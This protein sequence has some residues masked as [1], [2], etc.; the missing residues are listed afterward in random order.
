MTLILCWG[1][2][3]S[4]NIS[5]FD[6]VEN[7]FNFW[8][9]L[10]PATAKDV[11]WTIGSGHSTDEFAFD[12]YLNPNG[13]IVSNMVAALNSYNYHPFQM[14]LYNGWNH[15]DLGFSS[16]VRVQNGATATKD[17]WNIPS[18]GQVVNGR[19][20]PVANGGVRGKGMWL[21][22]NHAFVSY[23]IGLQPENVN[24]SDWY[25]GIFVDPRFE[26][27]NTERA[28][29][30]FP[31]HTMI[32]MLGKRSIRYRHPSLGVVNEI[33]LPKPIAEKE[34]V[35]L[36]FQL[37]N[38]GKQVRFLLNGFPFQEWNSPNIP[39]M[40]SV[41]VT[42]MVPIKEM[43]AVMK[44]VAVT[45]SVAV[46]EKVAITETVPVYQQFFSL[47]SSWLG[48]TEYV[49][50]IVGYVEKV[51]GYNEEIVGYTEDVVG[52]AE[53]IAGYTQPTM[54][55]MNPGQLVV[56]DTL[57]NA[58]TH[59]LT[60]TLANL[61]N[62]NDPMPEWGVQPFRGWIDGF[63][64]LA[65]SPDIES[66]CNHAKGTLVGL[67]SDSELDLMNVANQ[68]SDKMHDVV[69]EQLRMRGQ[70]TYDSYACYHDYS[71]DFAA[72]TKNIPAGAASLRTAIQFPEGPIYHDAPRP[73][74]VYNE[75]CLSCHHDKGELGLNTVALLRDKQTLAK[76]DPRRQ[77]SQPP[78]YVSGN[79]PANWLPT[80]PNYDDSTGD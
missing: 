33:T 38:Q 70:Q 8:E 73:E 44:T 46:T 76:K 11:V 80:S 1:L 51:V 35:H 77:P 40:E 59:G 57:K 29:I 75:L 7:R 28:I 34:W 65:H 66:S 68:Y 53:E 36:G 20:E 2:M 54:F 43:V 24:N 64:V 41:V 62:V 71:N 31:D 39:I 5:M 79:L 74:S 60:G 49:E 25:S 47:F 61:L 17:N 67:P 37:T 12:D 69:A 50:K 56:G 16:Q 26:D 42:A 45:E 10:K 21:N 48:I 22:G 4:I 18:H 27:D 58:V 9:H 72:H 3:T 15:E 78:R 14:T 19:M 55:Q 63:K 23:G 32:T 6:S 52:Y 30:N 13:F